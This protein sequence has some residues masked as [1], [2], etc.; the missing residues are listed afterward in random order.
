MPYTSCEEFISVMLFLSKHHI[1]LNSIFPRFPSHHSLISVSDARLAVVMIP[2]RPG[3]DACSTTIS[4]RGGDGE[5]ILEHSHRWAA[6][7]NPSNEVIESL[8]GGIFER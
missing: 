7:R 4:R 3:A 5:A 2:S 8:I 6:Q 1:A